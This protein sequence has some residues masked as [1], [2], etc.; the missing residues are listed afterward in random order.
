ML[1][2]TKI[3]TKDL[4]RPSFLQVTYTDISQKQLEGLL[5]FT[6]QFPCKASR[7]MKT[8]RNGSE[9]ICSLSMLIGAD[10]I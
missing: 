7:D 2:L 3:S 9:N 4:S 5:Q 8:G 6:P 1:I 10:G